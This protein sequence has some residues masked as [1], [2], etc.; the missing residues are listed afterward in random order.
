MPYD[1]LILLDRKVWLALDETKRI[2]IIE[3]YHA[4]QEIEIPGF[5]LHVTVHAIGSVLIRHRRR[6]ARPA[7]LT[8]NVPYFRALQ[9]LNA[10]Q[11]LRLG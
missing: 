11:W 4:E 8:P 7:T 10:K 2:A 1:P 9:R 3:Q 6:R 5:N